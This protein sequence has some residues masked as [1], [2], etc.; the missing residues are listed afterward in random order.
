MSHYEYKAIPAPHDGE[1]TYSAQTPEAR[2]AEALTVRLNAM[3]ADG[4]TYLRS[5]AFHLHGAKGKQD[6]LIFRR[7][8]DYGIFHGDRPDYGKFDPEEATGT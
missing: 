6:V 8:T 7:E 3:A 1:A 5:D 2:L 4:W